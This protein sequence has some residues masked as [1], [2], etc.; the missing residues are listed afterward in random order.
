MSKL[1]TLYDNETSSYFR[2]TF[3]Y[4]SCINF[5][6]GSLKENDELKQSKLLEKN[7]KEN[8]NNLTDETMVK[9]LSLTDNRHL[10]YRFG[11]V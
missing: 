2:E 3:T 6:I 1:I 7:Y 9:L 10:D 11:G 5:L 8:K 4:E